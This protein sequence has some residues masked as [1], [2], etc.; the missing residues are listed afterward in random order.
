MI[1]QKLFPILPKL[2]FIVSVTALT[3]L[4]GLFVFRLLKKQET[5]WMPKKWTWIAIITL[6]A[7]KVLYSITLTTLQYFTWKNDTGI[8]QY[9][10]PPHQSWN[11]FT[12]YAFL[13]FFYGTL[14]TL[15]STIVF[16]FALRAMAKYRLEIFED[17]EVELGTLCALIS[18]WPGFIIFAPLSFLILILFSLARKLA[19][20]EQFTTITVPMLLSIVITFTFW[21]KIIEFLKLTAL[22]MPS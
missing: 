15:V 9:F 12:G 8:G 11:Y 17:G 1:T 21:Q 7:F 3:L 6:T 10:L 16:Y 13:H 19:K 18:G 22:I 4:I 20:N 5:Y 14:L 2:P